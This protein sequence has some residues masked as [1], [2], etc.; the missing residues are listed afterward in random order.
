MR[1]RAGVVRAPGSVSLST[2]NLLLARSYRQG[3][4]HHHAGADSRLAADLEA[5]AEQR[6]PLAHTRKPHP[7]TGPAP[8]P[9]P[10]RFEAASPVPDLEPHE[11]VVASELNAHL[12]GLG[13]FAHIGQRFLGHA[14]QGGLQRGRKP[15]LPERLFVACIE[16]LGAE[17]L[18]L[19]TYGGGQPKVVE[20]GGPQVGDD[21]PGF[22][23]R[24]VDEC[25]S[26]NQLLSVL[27]SLRRVVLLKEHQ[28]PVGRCRHLGE[29]VVDLI[30]YPTTLL[31][32]GIY[33]PTYQIMQLAL[34]FSQLL[35][36]ALNY[37]PACLSPLPSYME[38][39]SQ[40]SDQQPLQHKQ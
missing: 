23:D 32:L 25:Y 26:I 34:T 30:G 5:A 4:L 12:V 28:T 2:V 7:L 8:L 35:L 20:R 33:H 38:L 29:P 21:A 14:K 27:R 16:P 9:H 15:I 6:D 10:C 22:G 37:Q 13:V 17:L 40:R 24:P 31:F 39:I 1:T 3:N 19:H 36:V 11:A 18:Y